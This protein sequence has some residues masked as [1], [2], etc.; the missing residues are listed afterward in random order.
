MAHTLQ[1]SA[2]APAVLCHGPALGA[3]AAEA[4]AA[5]AEAAEAVEARLI[6]GAAAA[7]EAPVVRL[8]EEG[9]TQQ[10]KG[11]ES[12]QTTVCNLL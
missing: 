2:A 12:H 8:R 3:L 4:A 11:E 1:L 6:T 9:S 5:G 10:P 7:F